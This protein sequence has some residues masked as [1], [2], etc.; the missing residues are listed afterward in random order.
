VSQTP[1]QVSLIVPTYNEAENIQ[2]LLT[3]AHAAVGSV[4]PNF[5]I[6][7]VDDRS[8]DSTVALA[9]AVGEQHANVRV[10]E[11]E[12]RRDLALSVIDGWRAARGEMV[13]VIDADLQHPPEMLTSLLALA[14]QTEADFAVA[15]RHVP[16]GGVSHWKLHRRAVSWIATLLAGFLIPGVLRMVRDPMSGFFAVRRRMIPFAS[17]HPRGY[18]ILLELLARTPYQ[19]LVEVPYVFEER[20][21]GASKL[22]YKQ[23][24]QYLRHVG[25]LSLETGEVALF[26][27]YA[28]VGASGIVVNALISQALGSGLPAQAAGFEASVVSNFLLNEFWTFRGR[29]SHLRFTQPAWQRFGWFQAISLGSMA[30]NIGLSAALREMGGLAAAWSAAAGILLGGICNF[31]ANKHLTWAFWRHDDIVLPGGAIR[32]RRK[33]P[34]SLES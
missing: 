13:A 11:R 5:E 32:R 23:V 25:R 9:R 10:I 33:P 1:V 27:R 4:E 3:R 30:L 14:R 16:G 12:G 2:E 22:G 29:I 26:L 19:N 31:L 8:T 20:K 17:L 6:L 24:M 21:R 7:V 15:S 28:A 18:K 34:E